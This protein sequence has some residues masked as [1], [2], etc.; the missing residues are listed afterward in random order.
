MIHPGTLWSKIHFCHWIEK[1]V[2]WWSGWPELSA[3]KAT[4]Q[5]RRTQ[6]SWVQNRGNNNDRPFFYGKEIW[7][8]GSTLIPR[9]IMIALHIVNG[10]L[11]YVVVPVRTWLSW[12]IFRPLD[13]R[14]D[15]KPNEFALPCLAFP[16]SSQKWIFHH[17]VFC[18][19]LCG[20]HE[21][22]T[23][24]WQ[25]PY[26]REKQKQSKVKVLFTLPILL[27]R[28]PFSSSLA[29]IR[30]ARGKGRKG[31]LTPRRLMKDQCKISGMIVSFGSFQKLKF[32]AVTTSRRS[33]GVEK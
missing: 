20:K 19:R 25:V 22:Q 6:S 21:C 4:R 23:F 33:L 28:N 8:F 5:L 1:V 14:V 11:A 18:W 29:I 24:G 17:E 7:V 16:W 13:L 3:P 26:Q 30:G 9:N 2:I 27:H 12:T 10:S 32:F 31:V 15:R